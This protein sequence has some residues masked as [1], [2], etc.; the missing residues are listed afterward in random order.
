MSSLKFSRGAILK[1]S[2]IEAQ[3]VKNVTS[4]LL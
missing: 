4:R 1:F 2:K 3:K